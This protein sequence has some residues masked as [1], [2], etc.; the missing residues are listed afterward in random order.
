MID[1]ATLELAQSP[2][3]F[4]VCPAE[5]CRAKPHRVAPVYEIPATV[6]R[7]AWFKV[8]SREPRITMLANDDPLL[9]AEFVQRSN[10]FKFPD[11]ITVRFLP[12]AGGRSTLAVYSRSVFGYTD[13]GANQR[14]VERWLRNLGKELKVNAPITKT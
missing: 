9:E 6:L 11:R 13:L 1:F 7:E 10:V 8:V 4:L 2:N 3:Q 12:L 5:F 14:R